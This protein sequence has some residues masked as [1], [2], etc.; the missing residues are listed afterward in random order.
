MKNLFKNNVLTANIPAV[1]AIGGVTFGSFLMAP[2][3]VSAQDMAKKPVLV[4]TNKVMPT[5]QAAPSSNIYNSPK[6]VPEITAAQITAP[7]MS[8]VGETVV[9]RKVNLLN[10]DLF[11]LE[12]RVDRLA[13]QLSSV[14][15]QGKSMAASYYASV[16]TINTQLQ[17]GTTPGNPRLVGKLN[18]A[19]K[20]LETLSSNIANLNSLSMEIADAASK[21]SYLLDST[22]SMYNLSGAIEEDHVRLAQIEDKINASLVDI[23]RVQNN[24]SDDITR[25]TAYL[26][27]ERD[28]L[29]TLALAVANGDL[30]GK[31]LASQTFSY[32]QGNAN[33][34]H[35][36]SL[37]SAPTAPSQR[38][39]AKIKF[40]RSNVEYEQPIYAA[41]QSAMQKYPNAKFEVVAVHPT[42]GNTAQ[43]A[44]ESTKAR[45]NA[46]KVLRSLTQM[47][48]P[49]DKIDLSYNS[50][51]EASTS[52]VHLF[53]R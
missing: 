45:R 2:N 12:S 18:I 13:A 46:E 5:T 15:Q 10:K 41:V 39:L 9:G 19:Q 28:N 30:Y 36:A 34:M 43:L 26:T 24:V 16:A 14:S 31:S 6:R 42:S 33:M 51:N 4:I 7:A 32:H 48:L 17:T 27:T 50:S 1:L 23:S 3:S 38:L 25:T 40:D 22:R 11:A 21:G 53:L 49:L 37:T 20:N 44:I 52:E 35:N 47:G 29:R 8:S